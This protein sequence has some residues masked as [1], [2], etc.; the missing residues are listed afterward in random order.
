M[1][2]LPDRLYEAIKRAINEDVDSDEFELCAIDLLR[3]YYP[4]PRPLTGGNDAG[5]D[6][7]FELPDGR[8][9]FIVSTT[10]QDVGRNLR[11]S[12]KSHLKAGGER[13]VVVLAT[14]RCVSGQMREK[15]TR[16]LDQEFKFTL[17]DVHDQ[18]EFI[19]L[20]CRSSKWRRD[21]LGVP[22]VAGAL[23][24][25]PLIAALTPPMPLIG[26]EAEL[27]Q[28]R[29][30][31][32]DLIVVG[33][34]GIGK[35][36]LFQQLMKEDWGLFDALRDI[37]ELEDAIRDSQPQRVIIDD[38]HLAPDDRISLVLHLRRE[39]E[40]EFAVVVVTWPGYRD[41]VK[42]QLPEAEIV[43]VEEVDRGEI[44]EVV[45][46]AGLSE[47]DGLLMEIND[48]VRGR[49]GLAVMLARACLFEDAF[50]VAT[51]R[52]LLADLTHWYKQA[53]PDLR[54]SYAEI[55]CV[56]ALAGNAGVSTAEVAAA[57]GESE[58]SIREAI[59]SLATGGTIDK[60]SS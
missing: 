31:Q 19:D 38:A 58:P 56:L 1:S 45:N 13:R 54:V 16:E 44:I 37:P 15:L 21:L 33:K 8:R 2:A 42:N 3:V 10:A 30:V 18:S 12:V 57:L 55:I 32:G 22:G 11:N 24:R 4:S 29:S 9:G 59:R 47:P 43:S 5:Q 25:I 34:P 35:T 26:R 46:A 60:V 53:L 7:L 27:E 17:H 40:G 49:A 41:E 48:Q 23:T 50:D 52:R 51:G 6:G 20:L 28:L 39:M 36:F 14:T